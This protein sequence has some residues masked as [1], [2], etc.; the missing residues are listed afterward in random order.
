[1]AK[2]LEPGVKFLLG[3]WLLVKLLPSDKK[4]HSGVVN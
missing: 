4:A 2:P 3:D 1:M